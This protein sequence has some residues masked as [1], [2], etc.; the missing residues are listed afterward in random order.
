M[1]LQ[2]NRIIVCVNLID[3]G[4]RAQIETKGVN[5]I[6]TIKENLFK[7]KINKTQTIHYLLEGYI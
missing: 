4:S 1:I 6:I 2:L 7:N 5:E 3:V